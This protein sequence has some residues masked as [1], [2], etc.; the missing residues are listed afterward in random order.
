MLD[1][2]QIKIRAHNLRLP[3]GYDATKPAEVEAVNAVE[4]KTGEV[5]GLPEL[6]KRLA[7]TLVPLG[8]AKTEAEKAAVQ[9][10]NARKKAADNAAKPKAGKKK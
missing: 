6:E 4:F 1:P 10:D 5:I 2:A 3:D 7:E 8:E 9:K